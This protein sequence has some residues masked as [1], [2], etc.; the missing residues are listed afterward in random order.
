MANDL[1]GGRVNF[2]KCKHIRKSQADK[3]QK[4][5]AKEG[6]VLITHKGTI[7]VTALLSKIEYPYVMLTP[8]VTYYRVVN[9][10][11]NSREFL[12]FTLEADSFQNQMIAASG[13][14]T[15][16]YIGIT[17]QGKLLIS[18]PKSL[19]EQQKVAD[20]LSSLDA[21]ITAQTEKVAALKAHKKG[22]MQQL[23][24]AC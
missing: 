9:Q 12:L 7:G 2:S 3:L 10:S 5:F 16:S 17:E 8:Q 11:K 1:R 21:L 23:F 14:G 4:G 6:D 22:L 20:C 19:L 15:R 18:L 13:G 24:P